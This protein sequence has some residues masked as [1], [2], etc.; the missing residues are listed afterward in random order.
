MKSE[1]NLRM[2]LKEALDN[3]WARIKSL[4]SGLDTRVTALEQGGG[5]G[6]QVNVIEAISF[7]G[8]NVPPDASK[9][10]SLQEA[11][12]TVP[13]W[14][15]ASSKPTYTASEVGALADTTTF[16]SGVK[17]NAESTYRSGQVNLTPANVG[18]LALSGGT[19]TGSINMGQSGASTTSENIV[20]ISENGTRFYIRTYNNQLQIARQPSGGSSATV[21][22]L[23]ADGSIGFGSPSAWRSALGLVLASG[24]QSF[25]NL[26][27]GTQTSTS[28]SFSQSIGTSNYIV[29]TQPNV[30]RC[31]IGIQNKT[32]NGFE[33]YCRNVSPDTSSPAV[34]WAAIALG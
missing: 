19:M 26:A 3:L 14:A 12:P 7:N 30:S 22:N 27:A 2:Q 11:D 29:V 4:V 13:S 5:G 34:A 31:A 16:V 33:M 20:L 25:S 6:G 32:A 21:L 1:N 23:Y 28:I 8:T 17:G 10:V 15:K 9:R 24:S 18:A